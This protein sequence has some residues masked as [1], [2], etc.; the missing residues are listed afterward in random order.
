MAGA[1]L[2]TS[3]ASAGGDTLRITLTQFD[4]MDD[5]EFEVALRDL[6]IRD[7]WSARK[8][9]QPG[10]QGADVIGQDRQR[11]RIVVQAKHT[12]VAGK[13]GSQVMYQVKGTACPVHGADIAVDQRIL[14]PRCQSVGRPTQDLLGRPGP[15]ALLGRARCAPAPPAPPAQPASR[16][17]VQS[18][19]CL[20]PA[21][22]RC[23]S[24]HAASCRGLTA[25]RF[26][27]PE[28]GR[29]R[30]RE[31]LTVPEG[32]SARAATARINAAVIGAS[33]R[34]NPW[35]SRCAH[36]VSRRC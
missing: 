21:S 20:T 26:G 34:R 27:Y 7:G 12:K 23:W 2:G 25:R 10:D 22:R 14:H 6:L 24:G 13:V 5:Q 35:P 31:G 15:T 30:T 3:K 11:G 16:T 33:L 18:A 29:K 4:A 28:P 36:S 1:A 9:G 32:V 8:V 19:C 17:S